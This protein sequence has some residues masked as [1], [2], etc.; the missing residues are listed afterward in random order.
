MKD[1][2]YWMVAVGGLV[3]VDDRENQGG[4]F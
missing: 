4:G 2:G 1:G 3:V